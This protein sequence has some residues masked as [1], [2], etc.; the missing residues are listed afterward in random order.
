MRERRCRV[1]S[2]SGLT[3][4]GRSTSCTHW[5][6]RSA[7]GR[8]YSIHGARHLRRDA[9][10]GLPPTAFFETLLRQDA[11]RGEDD[12]RRADRKST[13]LNSSHVEISYA[14]FCLKKK[15][16]DETRGYSGE[17]KKKE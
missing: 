3:L 10:A 1:G 8:N 7:F 5:R 16:K 2:E 14:V 6:H 15:K 9:A 12:A 11:G 4:A 17:K 13:R